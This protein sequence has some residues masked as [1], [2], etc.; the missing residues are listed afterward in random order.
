[1]QVVG[2]QNLNGGVEGGLKKRLTPLTPF[3]GNDTI[4]FCF[5]RSYILIRSAVL[6][7]KG[8]RLRAGV[9]L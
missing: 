9:K 2:I 8:F 4:D 7:A 1:M 5:R 6:R 3:R